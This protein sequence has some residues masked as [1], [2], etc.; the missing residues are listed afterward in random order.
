M[1]KASEILSRISDRRFLETV[2]NKNVDWDA[3]LDAR[4]A[5]DF[6]EAWSSSYD[7]VDAIDPSEEKVIREIRESVFKQT[8]RITQ[9]SEL[10]GYASDDFGLVAKAFENKIDI[11]F[12]NNLWNSYTKG[13]FP[14]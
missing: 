4:D 6:A 11:E 8:F 12:I 3:E 5:A 9:S 1:V 13:C 10:A 7:K 14:K 2:F